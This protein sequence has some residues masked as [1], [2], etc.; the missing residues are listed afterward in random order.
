MRDA[1]ALAVLGVVALALFV[2]RLTGLPNLL[3][4]E[5]RLG[6]SVM[7]VVRNGNW[8]CPRDALGRTDKPPMLTLLA[9]LPTLALGRIDAFTLYLP[10]AL[11]TF[12]LACVIY[13][14]GRRYFGRLAGFLAGWGYLLSETGAVQMGT[15]RWDGLFALT[16]AATAL[17]AFHA[18]T[19]GRGWTW[20]WL[21]GAA[22]TLTKGPLGVLL[23]ATGLVAVPWERHAGTPAPIRGRQGLGI[24]LFVAIVAGWFLLAYAQRGPVL[25]DELIRNELVSH[26]VE[27]APGRRFLEPSEDFL[28]NFAPWSLFTL[29][30]L[31]QLWC[32]PAADAAVRRFERFL[33]CWFLGGLLIFSISPHN[34]ARLLFPVIPPAALLAGRALSPW[35]ERL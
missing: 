22:W 27:H 14:T 35:V 19:T 25:I 21:A 31:Y 32:A 8:I 9:A 5:Y 18:W 1:L 2:I 4:N 24:V 10:T 6:A 26:A 16:V 20:F 29:L 23:A 7:D 34:P 12:V 30:A 11:A 17:A 15:A 3:D 28:G 33:A 13:T